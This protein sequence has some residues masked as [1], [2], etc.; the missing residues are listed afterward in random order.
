MATA[1]NKERHACG[2]S[3]PLRRG[4]NHFKRE[5]MSF[6]VRKSQRGDLSALLH[7][8]GGRT[9]SF[10]SCV[11]YFQTAGH[12]KCIIFL[13]FSH[14]MNLRAPSQT[15]AVGKCLIVRLQYGL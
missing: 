6:H 1:P 8:T 2:E 14:G 12:E 15:V 13:F 9:R 7:D 11:T 4:H 5:I 3:V 10:G